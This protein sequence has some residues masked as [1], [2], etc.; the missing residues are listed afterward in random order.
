[1]PRLVPRSPWSRNERDSQKRVC[2]YLE[3]TAKSAKRAKKCG[4]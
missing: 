2:A 1:M 3:R 4:F